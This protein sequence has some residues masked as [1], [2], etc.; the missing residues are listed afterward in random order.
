MRPFHSDPWAKLT[1]L[2]R[3]LLSYNRVICAVKLPV[4]IAQAA[5]LRRS[6]ISI[7]LT[8]GG[9]VEAAAGGS[10]AS[11]QIDDPVARTVTLA[12]LR[13]EEATASDLRSLLHR[14][15]RSIS[16]VKEAIARAPA[17]P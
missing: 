17:A 3:P 10:V 11:E 16:L 8:L 2:R 13:M 4:P 9:R 7:I 5:I 14:L 12:H 15:E 6:K 1:P